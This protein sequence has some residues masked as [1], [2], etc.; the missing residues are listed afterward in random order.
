MEKAKCTAVFSVLLTKLHFAKKVK[1]V[2]AKSSSTRRYDKKA[3]SWYITFSFR[4][5]GRC[6]VW[7]TC[8]SSDQSP[9]RWQASGSVG[10]FVYR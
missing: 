10:K 8:N 7:K 3:I 9:E 6:L 1:Q 4:N 5:V 2:R